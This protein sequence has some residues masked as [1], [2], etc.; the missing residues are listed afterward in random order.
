[1]SSFDT[2]LSDELLAAERP[3][4]P[5]VTF[6]SFGH[7]HGPPQDADLVFDV[8]F[9]PNA[10][11]L[12]ILANVVALCYALELPPPSSLDDEVMTYIDRD[13]RLDPFCQRL[14][15]VVD[16]LLSRSVREGKSGLVLGAS[17]S[18]GRHRSVVFAERLA[19]HFSASQYR[20]DVVHRDIDQRSGGSSKR[21]QVSLEEHHSALTAAQ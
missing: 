6:T 3:A 11:E 21:S 4:R 16:Y 2:G 20:C 13:G 7:K 14:V 12:K 19:A 1:M 17:C 8:S 5:A 15:V 18:G 9:L 10:P